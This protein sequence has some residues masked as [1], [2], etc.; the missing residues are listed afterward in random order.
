MPKPIPHSFVLEELADVMPITKPMFGA[1]GVYVNGKIVVI[2]RSKESSPRDNGVW[3][4]VVEGAHESL[5][6]I[7]P[8]MRSLELFGSGP[9]GWQI[10]PEDADDFEESVLRVCRLIARGDERIG[11]IPKA[12]SAKKKST[13]KKSP[14]NKRR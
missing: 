5:R 8:S 4:A 14:P 2:L 6:E 10:L 1:Y 9:T 12:K 3:L 7:F 13:K 11:K